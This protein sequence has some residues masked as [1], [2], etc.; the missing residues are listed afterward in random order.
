MDITG[1][2]V[3]IIDDLYEAAAQTIVVFRSQLEMIA[4]ATGA[5]EPTIAP[6]KKI[7]RALE[8]AHDDYDN[9]VPGPSISW[10]YDIVRGSIECDTENQI[11]CFITALL[12]TFNTDNFQVIRLKNR[13]VHPTPGGF[14]DANINI[15]VSLTSSRGFKFSHICELQVHHRIIHELG[16]SLNSHN[17]YEFFR[18]YFRGSNRTVEDR[19]S[20]VQRLL[21]FMG[22]ANDNTD[23]DVVHVVTQNILAS[24]DTTLMYECGNLFRYLN[25]LNQ[26][27]LLY[28]KMLHIYE[29]ELGPK[30]QRT[31]HTVNR[32]GNLYNSMGNY[33]AAKEMYE[34]ALIGYEGILG[35]D[36]E[37]TLDEARNIGI[38]LKKDV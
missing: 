23:T 30:R 27:L 18:S 15:R 31:L 11:A 8:K 6:L 29:K 33:V 22:A 32:L 17:Q 19:L 24:G 37:F 26:A 7:E 10:L 20:L 2:Y 16:T 3:T 25:E 5:P 1:N 38:V 36:H 28:M 21:L 13:F 35:P 12:H 34:C 14:R 4:Q 9:R